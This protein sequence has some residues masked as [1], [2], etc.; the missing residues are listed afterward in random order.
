MTCHTRREK[1]LLALADL[2]AQDL[3]DGV[4]IGHTIVDDGS[5]DGTS[6]A[7][8]EAFPDVEI[9][10][11]DGRLFWAG[12]MRHGWKEAVKDKL[13][14]YLLVYNDDVRL[15]EDAMARLV[16][17]SRDFLDNNGM[18]A[19]AV[20]GA[21]KDDEGRLSYG[22]VVRNSWWH[23]LRFVRVEPPIRGYIQ[24]HAMNMNACLITKPAL[25]EVGFLSEY[26]VH[27][28]ADYEYG[29]K[30]RKYGG[31]VL[32]SAG[33]SGT[34]ARN[35][36]EALSTERGITLKERYKRLLSAKEQPVGQRQA[37]YKEFGG[38]FWFVL[39]LLPYLSLPVKH[40]LHK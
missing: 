13:F 35:N 19:H 5:T 9:V 36:I 34:C 25:N 26:C 4:T 32:L 16:K 29:L 8:M 7:V 24:V 37:F 10:Q 21:F 20:V 40:I 15:Y 6:E 23:P 30:L 22:G 2:H 11:G 31:A 33:Y 27:G 1:T 3:P 17:A 39:F 38:K 18:Q 28:G 12:G 14:D